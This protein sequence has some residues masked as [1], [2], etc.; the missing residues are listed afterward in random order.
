MR[1]VQKLS[2]AIAFGGVTLSAMSCNASTWN[3]IA[4]GAAAASGSPY[5]RQKLML[6]GGQSHQIYLCCLNCNEYAS[7]SVF[8]QYGSFGNPYSVT[9]IKNHYSEYGS[10]YSNYSA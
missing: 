9:S 1:R 3:A 2:L 6:F 8:N 4:A 10:L 7:D 5:V